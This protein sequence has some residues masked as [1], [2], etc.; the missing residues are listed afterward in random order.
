MMLATS[1]KL[2][3]RS[4]QHL[5]SPAATAA[6]ASPLAKSLRSSNTSTHLQNFH[7][8]QQLDVTSPRTRARTATATCTAIEPHLAVGGTAP[9]GIADAPLPTSVAPNS[10][11]HS[12]NMHSLRN[13][14]P[15]S[16]A[17]RKRKL[18]GQSE[19]PDQELRRHSEALVDM[20][21][22][23]LSQR[24]RSEDIVNSQSSASE[25]SRQVFGLV[26]LMKTC[27]VSPH[28][29]IPRNRIYARYAEICAHHKIKPLNP[30]AFGKLVKLLFPEIKTRRLGVRGK[31]KYH[32]CGINLIG[33]SL[34][35]LGPSPGLFQGTPQAE[36]E[37]S[38]MRATPGLLDHDD[39][40]EAVASEIHNSGTDRSLARNG[41][42][43]QGYYKPLSMCMDIPI[44]KM[45][46][47]VDKEEDQF[48]DDPLTSLDGFTIPGL[49]FSKDI[50]KAPTIA[51]D[52]LALPSIDPFIPEGADRD[53]V[54]ILTALCQSHCSSL[55]EAI[56]FMHL[57]QFLNTL[58]SFHGTLTSPVQKLLSV[59]SILEWIQRCDWIMYKEMI[60]M[61]APLAL[62]IVPANVMSALRSLSM[63]LPQNIASSFRS[64]PHAF[65]Q[66]KLRPAYAFSNLIGRLLRVNDIANAAAKILANPI[67]RR[68]MLEDWINYVDS[69]SIVLR[70][71][72]C[73]GSRVLK[74]LLEDV[75]NLLTVPREDEGVVQEDV[76]NERE[77][78]K[79]GTLNVTEND[80]SPSV[81]RRH[82]PSKDGGDL[83]SSPVAD[84]HSDPDAPAEGIIER[85][86]QY[87]MSLP[88]QFPEISARVF[89]LYMNGILTA[90]L[91]EITLNGGEAFGA[92]WMVRCWI[93]EW[94]A[95]IAEQGGFLSTQS[96]PIP[97]L[98]EPILSAENLEATELSAAP[99]TTECVPEYATEDSVRAAGMTIAESRVLSQEP[100]GI[101]ERAAA[102]PEIHDNLSEKKSDVDLDLEVDEEVEKEAS[103]N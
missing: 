74:I 64:L 35:M 4:S 89:L 93:D 40:F 91:R 28:N 77:R 5:S 101:Q 53:S 84:K 92:W 61:L 8:D 43:N 82:R 79:I 49:Q 19:D 39:S 60:H 56:R 50:V 16:T 87:L 37:L 67:E 41:K 20:P 83:P 25:R 90:A 48:P 2:L 14:S 13:V 15:V 99:G 7:L 17:S 57:K 70:E 63:T 36:D 54:D 76:S 68:A 6:A 71:A 27:E 85:W 80:A 94:M 10:I 95:W 59:P 78:A 47:Q 62:Q 69:K 45:E 3:E 22:E 86:A 9:S 33:D 102:D 81:G 12:H 103:M 66:V 29:A 18:S 26:W 88:F 97:D 65:I 72:P 31:S 21:L 30:A 34:L 58:A 38:D 24:V 55:L 52:S 96:L 11:S 98:N 51:F 23:E 75:V 73:G 100:G 42:N 46:M 32:Y 44:D 1:P